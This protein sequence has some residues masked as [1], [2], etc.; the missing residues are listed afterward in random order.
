MIRTCEKLTTMKLFLHQLSHHCNRTRNFSIQNHR[1]LGLFCF[2]LVFL[3]VSMGIETVQSNLTFHEGNGLH[4]K[5]M[6]DCLSDFEGFKNIYLQGVKEEFFVTYNQ[7]TLEECKTL[8]C[9]EER[10]E[11]QS[12]SYFVPLK[13]CWVMN[14]TDD[15]GNAKKENAQN[16][17]HY[18]HVR[19]GGKFVP[20]FCDIYLTTASPEI[21][22]VA[23][24]VNFENVTSASSSGLFS[25]LRDSLVVSTNAQTLGE[26]D[27][28]KNGVADPTST[29][30][31]I[32]KRTDDPRTLKDNK[33]DDA[34]KTLALT[35]SDV[36]YSLNVLPG[37]EDTTAYNDVT[38]K[39]FLPRRRTTT[40]K[41][42][43]STA[44]VHVTAGRRNCNI[45]CQNGG[46][47][48]S[49]VD[50][51]NE[52]TEL[53]SCKEGYSGLYCENP[54]IFSGGI[55]DYIIP[56]A[57]LGVIIFILFIILLAVYL[58]YRK[59]TG[60]YRVKRRADKWNRRSQAQARRTHSF[61]SG[62]HGSSGVSEISAPGSVHS[63][64]TS[65]TTTSV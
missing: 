44:K 51:T 60:K 24:G 61:H 15:H 35:R 13:V 30:L 6:E 28:E 32:N 57:I 1:L 42:L 23:Y 22:S 65:S 56:V 53:C 19:P 17:F 46:K 39:A 20:N 16:W 33:D 3:D 37:E 36:T 12:F 47:C 62:S 59:R 11:C 45:P 50:E 27:E 43:T 8:C 64:A 26:N 52:R 25:H 58:L 40:L 7:T 55:A 5:N 34:S 4:H 54:E 21:S 48:S 10:F 63:T 41:P 38:K 14:V 9:K 29:S 18:H 31:D 49:V 2:V